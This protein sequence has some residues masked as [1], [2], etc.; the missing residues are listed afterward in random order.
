MVAAIEKEVQANI[1]Y[2]F[3]HSNPPEDPLLMVMLITFCTMH[4]TGKI[5][6]EENTS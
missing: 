5:D 1:L 2:V 4:T 6:R 3:Q